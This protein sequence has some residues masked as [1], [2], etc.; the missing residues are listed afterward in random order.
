MT[1]ALYTLDGAV[2]VNPGDYLPLLLESIGQARRRFWASIFIVDP[3][4]AAD[5]SLHVRGVLDAL[6]YAAWRGV[7]V[8]L[9]LGRSDTRDI[10]IANQ[11][12]AWRL[13]ARGV[14]VRSFDEA[15]G[16]HSK[17]FLADDDLLVL[18][19]HNWGEEAFLRHVNTAVALRSAELNGQLA[20]KFEHHWQLATEVTGNE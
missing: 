4:L 6:G 2:A 13:V 20:T 5:P 7:D 12:A 19:S 9:L 16:T 8:R 11:T 18:G 17:Y 1:T 3:R 15:G 14:P 10:A